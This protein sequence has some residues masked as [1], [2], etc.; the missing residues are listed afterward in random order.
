[1][2]IPTSTASPRSYF[3]MVITIVQ[4]LYAGF[5]LGNK[6]AACPRTRASEPTRMGVGGD[7][8]I[9]LGPAKQPIFTGHVARSAFC[10]P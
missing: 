10:L 9:Q 2:S 1:M 8:P 6:T 3:R 7:V 4:F 5:A